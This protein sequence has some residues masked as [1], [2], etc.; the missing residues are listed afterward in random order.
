MKR[1]QSP[2]SRTAFTL[3]SNPDAMMGIHAAQAMGD[4]ALAK[5]FKTIWELLIDK[6][7]TPE[8]AV[9]DGDEARVVLQGLKK[10]ESRVPEDDDPN[11][12][13]MLHEG[14]MATMLLDEY[15]DPRVLAKNDQK[16]PET[17]DRLAASH[18]PLIAQKIA[19]ERARALNTDT[20]PI[21]LQDNGPSTAEFSVPADIKASSSR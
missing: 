21:Q 1:T 18:E 14:A 7:M 2:N 10:I 20:Q 11:R 17:E 13:S 12:A 15:Y 19:P 5:K 16:G 9:F 8:R 3:S 4:E 6:Q